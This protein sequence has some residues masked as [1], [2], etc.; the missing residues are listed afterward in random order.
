MSPEAVRGGTYVAIIIAATVGISLLAIVN[1]YASHDENATVRGCIRLLVT[2]GLC[3]CLWSGF[4]W[5]RKLTVVLFGIA[6]LL[7]IG[8]GVLLWDTQTQSTSM[9]LFSLGSIYLLCAVA[10]MRNPD[11][12]KFMKEQRLEQID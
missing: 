2:I 8:M 9:V 11:I 7:G 12:R 4:G 3:W 1:S 5:A 10:L 6:G